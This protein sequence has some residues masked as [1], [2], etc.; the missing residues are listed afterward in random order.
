MNVQALA[1]LKGE[2]I[3]S[4]EIGVIFR[5]NI[6][7]RGKFTAQSWR[8]SYV[9]KNDLSFE[10]NYFNGKMGIIKSLSSQEISRSFP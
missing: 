2:L 10:K 1:D 9:C 3:T 5:Q 4:P 8:S 7:C 6:S